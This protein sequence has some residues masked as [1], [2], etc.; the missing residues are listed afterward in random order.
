MTKLADELTLII[1]KLP[2]L[3][4]KQLLLSH[5]KED[6]ET[7]AELFCRN[8]PDQ[9]ITKKTGRNSLILSNR[10]T[11][12]LALNMVFLHAPTEVCDEVADLLCS[13]D[14]ILFFEAISA[15][16]VHAT[17]NQMDE[18]VM[19]TLMHY[20]PPAV[21]LKLLARVR[22][23]PANKILILLFENDSWSR[24]FVKFIDL[25]DIHD[26]EASVEL[27]K[28]LTVFPKN[29]QLKLFKDSLLPSF[30][31]THTA[32]IDFFKRKPPT[33]AGLAILDILK[34]YNSGELGQFVFGEPNLCHVVFEHQSEEVIRE[35]MTILEKLPEKDI[36]KLLTT[37]VTFGAD[38]TPLEVAFSRK[39]CP[40]AAIVLI[41]HL[42][43]NPTLKPLLTA[44]SATQAYSPIHY[45]VTSDNSLAVAYYLEQS[46]ADLDHSPFFRRQTNMMALARE[47]GHQDIVVL[48]QAVLILRFI[49]TYSSNTRVDDFNLIA[50]EQV[51]QKYPEI[52]GSRWFQNK[53]LLHHAASTGLAPV[54]GLLRQHG[55]AINAL[56]NQGLTPLDEA[57]A[58]NHVSVLRVFGSEINKDMI[59]AWAQSLT[60]S[61]SHTAVYADLQALFD[62]SQA[63]TRLESRLEHYCLQSGDAY[64]YFIINSGKLLQHCETADLLIATQGFV[65]FH[66]D[67]LHECDIQ[68]KM[69]SFQL[70]LI[71]FLFTLSAEQ[72]SLLFS[73]LELNEQQKAQLALVCLRALVQPAIYGSLSLEEHYFYIKHLEKLDD[74]QS[75]LLQR[76]ALFHLQ[77]SNLYELPA[78]IL[79]FFAETITQ[80]QLIECAKNRQSPLLLVLTL[81][82]L[83][84]SSMADECSIDY[85]LVQLTEELKWFNEEATAVSKDELVLLLNLIQIPRLKDFVKNIV[86]RQQEGSLTNKKI[87]Q[88]FSEFNQQ[89]P[90]LAD[91]LLRTLIIEQA[92]KPD[93]IVHPENQ[94]AYKALLAVTNVEETQ[95]LVH[96]LASGIQSLQPDNSN[97]QVCTTLVAQDQGYLNF[98]WQLHALKSKKHRLNLIPLIDN[99]DQVIITI[100][101]PDTRVD[102]DKSVLTQKIQSLVKKLHQ[103][104]EMLFQAHLSCQGQLFNQELQDLLE[105]MQEDYEALQIKPG[106]SLEALPSLFH[107][108]KDVCQHIDSQENTSLS[109]T[110]PITAL[111]LENHASLFSQNNYLMNEFNQVIITGLLNNA[112]YLHFI[113]HLY[114][115]LFAMRDPGLDLQMYQQVET[116]LKQSNQQDWEPV[117]Q[118]IDQILLLRKNA[119]PLVCELQLLLLDETFSLSTLL[120]CFEKADIAQL[121]YF[122]QY[123]Q[124]LNCHD[125]INIIDFV[126]ASK[127]IELPVK[128]QLTLAGTM[129]PQ[130][131]KGW[132][133][134]SLNYLANQSNRAMSIRAIKTGLSLEGY[135]NQL[136]LE[137][138]ITLI[139]ENPGHIDVNA[140]AMIIASYMP[141]LSATENTSESRAFIFTICQWL[142]I[143]RSTLAADTLACLSAEQIDCLTHHCLAGVNA[144]DAREQAACRNLMTFLCQSIPQSN[145]GLAMIK[146]RLGYQDLNLLNDKDLIAI[147]DGILAEKDDSLETNTFNALW[148]LR[149]LRSPAFIAASTPQIMQVLI[150][151]FRLIS[152]TLKQAEFKQL[153]DWLSKKMP[154]YQH[155][156]DSL[157]R[158]DRQISTDKQLRTRLLEKRQRLLQF[159]TNDSIGALLVEL[160]DTCLALKEKNPEQANQALGVLYTYHNNQQ[161][162]L[163]LDWL[164][165]VANYVVS[166]SVGSKGD[167]PIA[168]NTLLGWLIHYLPHNNFEQ[169]ELHRKQSILLYDARAKEIGFISESNQ[170]MMFIDDE[171]TPMIEQSQY[172]AGTFF[173]DKNRRIMGTLTPSGE[174]KR[175]NIYQKHTSALL[176]AKVPAEELAKSPASLKLLMLDV[177]NE[178]ALDKLYQESDENKHEWLEQQATTYLADIKKPLHQDCLKAIV[179]HH[180]PDSIYNLLASIKSA[181]NSHHLFS[182]ILEDD[183]RRD[184]LFGDSRQNALYSYFDRQDVKTILADFLVHYHD[185]AW[186]GEGLEC[187]AKYAVQTQSPSLLAQSLSIIEQ[188]KSLS[189]EQLDKLLRALI[190]TDKTAGIIW[191]HFLSADLSTNIQRIDKTQSELLTPFFYRSLSTFLIKELNSQPDWSNSYQYRL[192]LLIL[193]Q[194][195]RHIFRR[196]EL[197]Y[198]EKHAWTTLELSLYAQFAKKHLAIQ[199]TIDNDKVIAKKLISELLFRCANFGDTTLFYTADNQFDLS[200]AVEKMERSFLNAIAANVYLP[201]ILKKKIIG[202]AH[203]LSDWFDG[204][205]A[206]IKAIETE[207]HASQAIIDWKKIND[208][209]WELHQSTLT[210]P[211]ISAFLI[212]YSGTRGPLIKLLEDYCYQPQLMDNPAALYS[213]SKV[214]INLPDRDVSACIFNTL[215]QRFSTHPDLM[216]STL[217]NHLSNY[218]ANHHLKQ[219]LTPE[220]SQLALIKHFGMQKKYPLVQ[221]SCRLFLAQYA[222]QDEHSPAIDLVRQ[223]KQEA[224]LENDLSKH[225]GRFYFGIWKFINRFWHYGL[226]GINSNL[227]VFCDKESNYNNPCKLPSVIVTPEKGG[228]V[229]AAQLELHEK[230]RLIKKRYQ[231]FQDKEAKSL[232]TVDVCEKVIP[233]SSFS[234]AK[235]TT[236]FNDNT[237]PMFSDPDYNNATPA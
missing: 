18:R 37:R 89:H 179:K 97:L 237:E 62:T 186:F 174:I 176:M 95:H 190:G 207:L 40:E 65:Q 129:N 132:L 30:L 177:F 210:M 58:N 183:K 133:D 169:N 145:S 193:D 153:N 12:M 79:L 28:L 71:A 206:H 85:F 91:S 11:Y 63:Q 13:L 180:H 234:K 213:L 16:A 106:S 162:G 142:S 45:A 52:S 9:R 198:S 136:R 127:E 155:H 31:T 67:S 128:N 120:G 110:N 131:L 105:K 143:V 73:R 209:T 231:D 98:Y 137:Q 54:A 116:L 100:T 29:E 15:R 8:Y 182:A 107:D 19:H 92:T 150:E 149:L 123:C 163:R 119:A 227:V 114:H 76:L 233:L 99:I 201:H 156:Q 7:Q 43:K 159:R 141:L 226:K 161:T 25:M 126:M 158:V 49:Q 83:F 32:F 196:H 205:D 33:K 90:I 214:M 59:A 27:I 191:K 124:L 225:L 94:Q 230:Y 134:T 113:P 184:E 39:D 218:H 104:A 228:Q 5:V 109:L 204:R 166:Q 208:Q 87:Q 4:L 82:R 200:M 42:N 223:I 74:N 41:N 172:P 55:A 111:R 103:V 130:Q 88:L 20:A 211:I 112:H 185:K 22:K 178:N 165:Q 2:C 140:M 164:F 57:L 160:E 232:K 69:D 139:E 170:A 224:S 6:A 78:E 219:T 35:L 215:E 72:F 189:E 220:Q 216:D 148:F 53:T 84:T 229:I 81:Q 152:L 197:R 117:D 154:F 17:K 108:I 171:P 60:R 44:V 26:S 199:E 217:F 118:Q 38:L 10:L 173:Y 46:D 68:I 147:A 70:Q 47:S 121:N 56:D 188:N 1:N 86:S 51:I 235:S 157:N 168:Q 221:Q 93:N 194:Q 66:L 151:R 24:L 50:M 203:L 101:Q 202:I 77:H 102:G 192:L 96:T 80:E 122:E 3:S 222:K 146:K 61:G 75:S 167:I 135:D 144:Q 236:F 21:K 181:K 187:F 48:L 138:L 64:L 125:L 195:G 34:S 23:L 175:D 36:K 115:W 212:N 14:D